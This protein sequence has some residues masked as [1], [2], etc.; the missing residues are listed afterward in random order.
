M[1]GFIQWIKDT[2]E[3]FRVL[4]HFMSYAIGLDLVIKAIKESEKDD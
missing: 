3:G 2:V 4:I 1:N